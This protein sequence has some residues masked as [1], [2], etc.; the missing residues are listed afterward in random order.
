MFPGPGERA[1]REPAVLVA[2]WADTARLEFEA[3]WAAEALVAAPAGMVHREGWA[4]KAPEAAVV[5][6]EPVVLAVAWAVEALV[7]AP[8]G[9][10]HR[11]GWAERERSA[12]SLAFLDSAGT[13]RSVETVDS[14]GFPRTQWTSCRRA[15]A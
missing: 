13:V 9:M 5:E 15:A 11:E 10:V 1:E 12:G 3:A 7:A 14:V 6:R 4:G 8:A 2:G